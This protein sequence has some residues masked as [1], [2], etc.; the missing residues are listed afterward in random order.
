MSRLT[1]KRRQSNRGRFPNV[2][3]LCL[4]AV[5][6]RAALHSEASFQAAPFFQTLASR[7]LL[8]TE[9]YTAAPWTLP[10]FGTL[11]TGLYPSEHGADSYQAYFSPPVPTLAERI[12][13]V[14]ETVC[15]SYNPYLS[16]RFN[17]TQGFDRTYVFGRRIPTFF[18]DR[19]KHTGWPKYLECARLLFGSQRPVANLGETAA[20]LKGMW[21]ARRH[22]DH[23]ASRNNEIIREIFAA[24]G[25]RPL[26]VLANYM[27]A[28]W[29]YYYDR[30]AGFVSPPEVEQVRAK[31]AE[32]FPWGI[33]SGQ[34]ALS[35]AEQRSFAAWYASAVHYLDRKIRELCDGL[36][37]DDVLENTYV[38]V[39]ADHGEMLGENGLYAHT[40]TLHNRV[41][42][43]PLLIVP[44][45]EG[46]QVGRIVSK[47]FRL[48]DLGALLV[49]LARDGTV[50]LDQYVDNY[51]S[52]QTIYAEYGGNHDRLTVADRRFLDDSA[53]D[54]GELAALIDGDY[55]FVRTGRGKEHLYDLRSDP[56]EERDVLDEERE[57][58]AT[59]R[60]R[61]ARF[62][63]AHTLSGVQTPRVEDEALIER[64]RALGYF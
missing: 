6:A 26:F 37:Q 49:Q 4:D 21:T 34:V 24:R 44:P 56:D 42:H 31:V 63:R 16:Y 22:A 54:T 17:L 48:H 32:R 12:G 13:D 43:V 38:I 9:C 2:L 46:R 53:Y 15:V 29:P 41:L 45:V 47:R 5:R 7:G 14:Y 23:G 55:K 18:A 1:R 11:F 20:F 64:L 51:P 36:A 35:S 60:A 61:I 59:M 62:R 57:V 27:E 40:L 50:E 30:R 19:T 39:F 28:H 33:M 3:L 25:E 52:D 58:A 8:F 10:S